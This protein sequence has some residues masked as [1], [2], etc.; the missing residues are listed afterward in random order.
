MDPYQETYEDYYDY[1]NDD[2]YPYGTG[3]TNS[4]ELGSHRSYPYES[5]RFLLSISLQGIETI[6]CSCRDQFN[7]LLNVITFL[8]PLKTL[9]LRASNTVIMRYMM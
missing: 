1:V 2:E 6:P 9:Q 4:G 3:A 5:T 7:A 8:T